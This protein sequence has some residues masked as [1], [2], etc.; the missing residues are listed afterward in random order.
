MKKNTK[1]LLAGVVF[2]VGWIGS[3]VLA[4]QK[5]PAASLTFCLTLVGWLILFHFSEEIP[6][7]CTWS[8]KPRRI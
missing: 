1:I 3:V 5:N 2:I 4:L 6:E 8:D 7:V